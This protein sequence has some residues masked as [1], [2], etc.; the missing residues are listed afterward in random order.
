MA[1]QWSADFTEHAHIT[2]VKDPARSGNNQ[3]HES[4]ICRY[5]DR[6]ERV[7]NFDLMT[8]IRDSG[9]RFDAA[10]TEEEDEDE[11]EDDGDSVASTTSQLLPFLWTSGYHSGSS[12]IV[13]YFYKAD[14]VKRGLLNQSFLRPPR[15]YQSAENTVYHLSRDP[16]YKKT[17]TE[18]AQLY[19]IPD[20]PAAIGSFIL[21]V[22][23]DPNRSHIDSVGG[24]RRIHNDAL[25]VS[26]LQ[27]W[28]KVRIQTKS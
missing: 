14:L 4:Q 25:P 3:G 7:Q 8:A 17:I 22:S 1:C 23:S 15:T 12:R 5:L 2:L 27:I 16:N 11:D 20:L 24:R 9:V 21:L 19:N 26:R 6:Q 10:C 18:A 13:D 28:K